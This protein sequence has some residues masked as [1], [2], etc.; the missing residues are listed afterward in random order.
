MK[1]IYNFY[2]NQNYLMVARLKSVYPQV[3]EI[4]V[5]SVELTLDNLDD[6]LHIFQNIV[7]MTLLKLDPSAQEFVGDIEKFN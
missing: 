3:G 4:Y 5:G 7:D 6:M 2:I 1:Q